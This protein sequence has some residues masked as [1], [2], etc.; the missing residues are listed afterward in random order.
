VSPKQAQSLADELIH[1]VAL[2]DDRNRH[3][4]LTNANEVVSRD[5]IH[6]AVA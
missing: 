4:L 6:G 5:G 1:K 3:I 2:Q